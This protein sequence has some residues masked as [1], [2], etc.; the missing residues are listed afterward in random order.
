VEY[1]QQFDLLTEMNDFM[2]YQRRI[3]FLRPVDPDEDK[4]GKSAVVIENLF[5]GIEANREHGLKTEVHGSQFT[6][7]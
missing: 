2:A 3:V 1:K 4:K 5:P 7:N 6:V